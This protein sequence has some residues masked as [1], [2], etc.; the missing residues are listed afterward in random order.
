MKDEQCD[1]VTGLSEDRVMEYIEGV[2]DGEI[3]SHVEGCAY[4]AYTMENRV[5]Q[6]FDAKPDY[7]KLIDE[8]RGAELELILDGVDRKTWDAL[9]KKNPPTIE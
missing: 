1:Y 8:L 2:S 9:C 3:L 5:T 4:C 7:E 6:L